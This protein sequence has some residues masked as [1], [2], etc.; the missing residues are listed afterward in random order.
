MKNKV[1]LFAVLFSIVLSPEIM[2]QSNVH[3]FQNFLNEASVS[4]APFVSASFLKNGSTFFNALD[5]N[6]KAAYPLTNSLEARLSFGPDALGKYE[7]RQTDAAL[8]GIYNLMDSDYLV[9]AG[10]FVNLPL[11]ENI[12]SQNVG[13]G[14]FGA[15]KKP[16]SDRIILTADAGF[17]IRNQSSI[18]KALFIGAGTI[19][20]AYDKLSVIAEGQFWA[21]DANTLIMSGGLDYKLMS[22][23]SLRGVLGFNLLDTGEDLRALFGASYSF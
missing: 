9:S 5:Y 17:D 1:A 12:R 8:S 18:T 22:R 3:L 7:L 14:I 19:I 16:V 23:I 11:K 21:E 6:I 2:P 20:D 4:P 10:A 13:Y 15:L